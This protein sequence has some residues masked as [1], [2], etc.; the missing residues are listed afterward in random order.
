MHVAH[1]SATHAEVEATPLA[2]IAAPT[3]RGATST[4]LGGSASSIAIFARSGRSTHPGAPDR[5]SSSARSSAGTSRL[6][7]AFI[8]LPLLVEVRLLLELHASLHRSF[9]VHSPCLP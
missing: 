9:H 8:W 2:S 4:I 6:V 7:L 3:M 5:K 1:S